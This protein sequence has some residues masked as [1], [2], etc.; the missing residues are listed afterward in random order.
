MKLA[1][2]EAA[3]WSFNHSVTDATGAEGEGQHS[4]PSY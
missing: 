3:F 1:A 2:V 4:L